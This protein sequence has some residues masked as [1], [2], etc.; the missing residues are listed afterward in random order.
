MKPYA[1]DLFKPVDEWYDSHSNLVAFRFA[2]SKGV[3]FDNHNHALTKDELVA[4]IGPDDVNDEYPETTIQVINRLK[5]SECFEN[6][7]N[8]L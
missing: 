3:F 8:M 2:G 4:L 6:I 1:Y 5:K 7:L